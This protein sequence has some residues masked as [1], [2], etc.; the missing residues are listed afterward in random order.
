MHVFTKSKNYKTILLLLGK[1]T[2][3][4]IFIS[5]FLNEIIF[6]FWKLLLSFWPFFNFEDHFWGQKWKIQ[7]SEPKELFWPFCTITWPI[8][9]FLVHFVL[10]FYSKTWN[11]RYRDLKFRDQFSAKI[12]PFLLNISRNWITTDYFGVLY[13]TNYRDTLKTI[14]NQV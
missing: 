6:L 9:G 14:K 3:P 12:G 8:F 4:Y 10:D 5:Y 2:L 11:I 1:N 7:K 13:D